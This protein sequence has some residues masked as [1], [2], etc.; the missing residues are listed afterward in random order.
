MPPARGRRGYG[1]WLEST[2]QA[3]IGN[4]QDG[5]AG[6]HKRDSLRR[7]CLLAALAHASDRLVGFLDAP[8]NAEIGEWLGGPGRR[9]Y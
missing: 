7:F 4:P 1:N 9:L 6:N 5:G 8:K 2:L 3:E